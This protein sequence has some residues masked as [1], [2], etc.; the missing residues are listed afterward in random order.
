MSTKIDHFVTNGYGEFVVF[1]LLCKQQEIDRKLF[2][3]IYKIFCSYS[4][5]GLAE[6]HRGDRSSYS[7]EN[8]FILIQE[9]ISKIN[10]DLKIAFIPKT[11]YE[12]RFI[13][14]SIQEDKEKTQQCPW[15]DKRL[16]DPNFY[17]RKIK[18][19]ENDIKKISQQ[20]LNMPNEWS[21]ID[22]KEKNERYIR[23][24]TE[25]LNNE[26]R[27]I[28]LKLEKMKK[29]AESHKP[30]PGCWHSAYFS[31]EGELKENKNNNVRDLAYRL[32][33]F[34]AKKCFQNGGPLTYKEIIQ[35]VRDEIFF[36]KNYYKNGSPIL[37][38]VN[39]PGPS[40]CFGTESTRGSLK[41]MG[42]R[43]E[44]DE[45]I[46]I[47][48]TEL[49]CSELAKRH[50]ILYRGSNPIEDSPVLRSNNQM[51]Y[52]LSYGQ[53]LFSGAIFDPGAT[54][55]QCIRNGSH[56][57]SLLIPAEQFDN[58]CFYIPKSNTLAQ[59]C[60]DGELF[61]SR[62]KMWNEASSLESLGGVA[63]NPKNR[64]IQCL[65]SSLSREEFLLQFNEFKK[66]A[67]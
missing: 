23:E 62:T 22:D 2:D 20:I 14:N 34:F 35:L 59:L 58:C 40:I 49:E 46:I 16:H 19:F 4:P 44:Q 12:L 51:P 55:F 38:N 66:K 31:G 15:L 39:V 21:H 10:T 47:K 52:S 67:V 24:D 65:N 43:N 7:Y 30:D 18:R 61:H 6:E 25:K 64:N 11:L 41:P 27:D 28:E 26:V 45:D 53:G 3:K 63:P 54:A 33:K 48:A 60:G 13:H 1:S 42:I 8:R 17:Q 50:I 57:Y 37:V 56:G 5:G 36:L 9:E 29:K 32:N